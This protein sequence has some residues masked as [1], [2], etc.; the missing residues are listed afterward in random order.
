[1]LATVFR[2]RLPNMLSDLVLRDLVRSFRIE[3][4]I[5]PLRPPAWDLSAVLQFLNSLVFEPLHQASLRD[6]TKKVLFLVSLAT[7]KCVG[8]LQAVSR[9]V[10]FVRYDACLSYG[11]EFVAKTESLSNPL[12]LSFLVASLSDF[13]AGLGDELLLCPVRALRIYLDRT[14]SFSPLPFHRRMPFLSSCVRSSMGLVLVGQRLVRWEPIV[15]GASLPQGPFIRIGLLPVCLSQLPGAPIL[16][17]L[18]LISGTFS[19]NSTFFVPWGRS[20]LQVS[21]SDSSHLFPLFAGR[22]ENLLG[23]ESLTYLRTLFCA[24]AKKWPSFVI[25]KLFKMPK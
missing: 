18:P 1:M 14:S 17:L 4:P 13:V 20:W 6:L 12:P 5:R 10:S 25:T 15:S 3:A 22:E 2:F 16:S 21:E 9:A 19:T 23:P 8:E 11:P 24:Y 7:A